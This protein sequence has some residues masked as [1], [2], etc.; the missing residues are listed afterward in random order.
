MQSGCVDLESL[1]IISGEKVWKITVNLSVIATDGN[2]LD[3]ASIAT[4][5]SLADFSLPAVS[6][7][8]KCVRV[9]NELDRNPVPLVM[10]HLPLFNTFCLFNNGTTII[11]D[12]GEAE[13]RLAESKLYIAVNARQ[14]LCALK[15]ASKKHIFPQQVFFSLFFKSIDL[16][17]PKISYINAFLWR[18]KGLKI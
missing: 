13:E 17:S 4:V 12:P 9:W 8:G 6:V 10:N 3:C 18:R 15:S 1:C 7:E 11:C 5:S 2:V 14:E 16:F